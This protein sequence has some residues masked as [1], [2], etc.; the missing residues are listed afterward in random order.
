VDSDNVRPHPSKEEIESWSRSGLATW[1]RRPGETETEATKHGRSMLALLV[2]LGAGLAGTD[3]ATSIGG[4]KGFNDELTGLLFALSGGTLV[5]SFVKR[6][7]DDLKT[8]LTDGVWTAAAGGAGLGLGLAGLTLTA[9]I[10]TVDL[11]IISGSILLPAAT[12]M[13]MNAKRGSKE[14]PHC[15]S[16][17]QSCTHAV[18]RNC[19]RIF[20]STSA[21]VLIR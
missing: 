16:K 18:C 2:A 19:L 21:G 13:Y 17:K 4:E 10:S 12:R 8:P 15:K 7:C 11:G 3:L 9:L 6:L 20:S 14:C 5:S 1:P